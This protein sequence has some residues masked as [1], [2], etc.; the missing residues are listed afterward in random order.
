ME[1]YFKAV[2]PHINIEKIETEIAFLPSFTGEGF[3]D[4]KEFFILREGNGTAG[5]YYV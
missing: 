4:C 1:R 5:I 3:G 2:Q